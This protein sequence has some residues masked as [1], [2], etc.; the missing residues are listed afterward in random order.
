MQ[1]ITIINYGH[2]LQGKAVKSISSIVIIVAI[3]CGNLPAF[4]NTQ[5]E[6]TEESRVQHYAG[7]QISSLK[8]AQ[9]VIKHGH[10]EL[11]KLQKSDLSN[12][13]IDRIHELT[14]SLENAYAYMLA[15]HQ[16]VTVLLEALHLASETFDPV[17][18]QQKATNYLN[19][20]ARH[21]K[22]H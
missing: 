1:I 10:K 20:A 19:E 21:H 4:A 7:E 18:V 14:Y 13:D 9:K 11:R 17:D 15:H 5:A 6:H 3:I 2:Y 12:T 16:Q 8:Q 22:H